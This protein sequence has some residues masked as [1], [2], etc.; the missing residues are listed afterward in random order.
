[1][2]NTLAADVVDAASRIHADHSLV[3]FVSKTRVSVVDGRFVFS[4]GE[5]S[6]S[7]AADAAITSLQRLVA[8]LAGFVGVDLMAAEQALRSPS[9]PR[10]K[11]VP[12]RGPGGITFTPAKG[13][14]PLLIT[15]PF[16]RGQASLE[17]VIMGE[18]DLTPA[19]LAWLGR[20]EEELAIDA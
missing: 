9:P 19:Q 3:V 16:G 1:M 5:E 14:E 18:F 8:H 4:A 20:I 11:P 15:L 10:R 6:H 13:D 7:L 12:R 2:N 17:A